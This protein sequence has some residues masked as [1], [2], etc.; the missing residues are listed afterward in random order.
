MNPSCVSL[1]LSF[2]IP[3]SSSLVEPLWPPNL[4]SLPAYSSKEF[5][6]SNTKIGKK[7]NIS[8]PP[9]SDFYSSYPSFEQ[10]SRRQLSSL[11]GRVEGGEMVFYGSSDSKESTQC[12]RLGFDPWV[13]KIPCRRA[14]QPTPIFLAEVSP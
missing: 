1:F 7:K 6:I 5:V 13:G 10:K 12:R 14:W 3:T 11:N 4:L 2:P 8:T 9:F